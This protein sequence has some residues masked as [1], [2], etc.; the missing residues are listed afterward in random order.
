[1]Q[2][3]GQRYV[4]ATPPSLGQTLKEGFAFGAGKLATLY[5]FYLKNCEGFGIARGVIGSM[6]GGSGSHNG[7]DDDDGGSGEWI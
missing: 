7:D 6:F 1:M 3:A 5:T 2:E 4:A